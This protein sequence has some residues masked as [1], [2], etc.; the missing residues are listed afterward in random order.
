MKNLDPTPPGHR[1]GYS[2]L[3]KAKFPSCKK[4]LKACPRAG[5]RHFSRVSA[6][7]Q[8][9][10]SWFAACLLLVSSAAA[11]QVSTFKYEFQLPNPS[12]VTATDPVGEGKESLP[13]QHRMV[14]PTNGALRPIVTSA[15]SYQIKVETSSG[16]G[17]EGMKL[18]T[19]KW[20]ATF[21]TTHT[22]GGGWFRKKRRTI[23]T[24]P[25][26]GKE[27]QQMSY[28]HDKNDKGTV[29]ICL[30]L[31]GAVP[32]TFYLYPGMKPIN[33]TVTTAEARE[34]V[35]TLA[36]LFLQKPAVAPDKMQQQLRGKE[37]ATKPQYEGRIPGYITASPM[38]KVTLTLTAR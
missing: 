4:S 23:T 24:H 22:S 9:G 28:Q 25:L 10:A 37:N 7:L 20:G 35:F 6:G 33:G 29:G 27:D 17:L 18:C 26:K 2:L 3:I 8:K 5:S 14:E 38:L 15:M 31:K 19:D 36:S 21:T 30:T 11:Q 12:A 16:K 32:E 1:E 34:F 13:L